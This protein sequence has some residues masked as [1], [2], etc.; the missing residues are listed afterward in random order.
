[1]R[2]IIAAIMRYLRRKE[3]ENRKKEYE[4]QWYKAHGI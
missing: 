1:M 3:R 4:R 2:E